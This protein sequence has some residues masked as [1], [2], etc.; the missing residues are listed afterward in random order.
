MKND[1]LIALL[2]KSVAE[3]L[4]AVH[5][6]MYFH[7]HLEDQGLS[8]LA[9]LFQRTAI[10]EMGHVEALADRILFL[11]GDVEMQAAGRVEKITDPAAMLAK[12]RTME[13][14]S[15][16]GYNQAAIECAAGADAASRQLFDRL[17]ADEEGHFAGFDRQLEKIQQFGASYLALQSMGK[18]AGAA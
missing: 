16:Q 14:V 11:K 12:A 2:N 4:L 13:E 8:P 10:T 15:A 3:E 6:Y 1:H 9:L 18:A 5:Q 7:I 17:V